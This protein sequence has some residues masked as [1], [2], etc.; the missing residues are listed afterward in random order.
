MIAIKNPGIALGIFL[1]FFNREF[2]IGNGK[3]SMVANIENA[4]FEWLVAGAVLRSSLPV[5]YPA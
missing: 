2:V 4:A 1:L 5:N 3:Y